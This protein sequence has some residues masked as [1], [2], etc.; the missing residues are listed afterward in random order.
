MSNLYVTLRLNFHCKDNKGHCRAFHEYD[1]QMK[2]PGLINKILVLATVIFISMSSFAQTSF[3]SYQS[4]NWND[5]NTWTLDPSGTLFTNP[6]NLIPSSTDNVKIN[7]GHNVLMTA[8]AVTV[9]LVNIEGTLDL[10]A[11][12]GHT[13]TNT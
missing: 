10:A 2:K 13:F 12:S 3:Y 7:T 4:G 8:N 6:S 5:Y 1:R 9:N 11:T